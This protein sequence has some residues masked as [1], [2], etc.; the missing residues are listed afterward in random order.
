[1]VRLAFL[2]CLAAAPL[3][4]QEVLAVLSSDLASY[5]EAHDGF[6]AAF[7]PGAGLR[8]LADGG[9]SVPPETKVIVAFGRKAAERAYPSRVKV[10]AC[11]APGLPSGWAGRR[12][13]VN[14]AMLPPPDQLLAVLKGVSPGLKRL[15]VIRSASASASEAYVE[16]LRQ[17]SSRFGLAIRSE[18]LDRVEDLPDALR[19]LAGETNALWL[20]PDPN[21]LTAQSFGMI[22]AFGQAGRLPVFVSVSGLAEKGAAVSVFVPFSENGRAAAAAAR[23]LLRGGALE[24]QILPEKTETVINLTAAKRYG[25]TIPPEALSRANLVLP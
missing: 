21:I 23:E 16:R 15:A 7:G 11:L 18:N 13:A 3:R 17:A 1:M 12:S 10:I 5:R 14:I 6:A 20:A 24:S 8:R 19:G 4:A 22:E 2:L 25:L 9:F